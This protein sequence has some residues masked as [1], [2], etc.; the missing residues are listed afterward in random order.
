MLVEKNKKQD[1]GKSGHDIDR[2][3]EQL[4]VSSFSDEIE[5]RKPLIKFNAPKFLDYKGTKNL[6]THVLHF[7]KAIASISPTRDKRYVMMCKLFVATLYDTKMVQQ[8]DVS[9]H[10]LL[11]TI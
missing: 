9:H 11:R 2:E 8:F 7:K 4:S 10:Y 5:R 1:K 6:V 3:Y